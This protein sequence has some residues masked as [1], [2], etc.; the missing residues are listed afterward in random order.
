MLINDNG[1]AARL[2]YITRISRCDRHSTVGSV[3][4]LLVAVPTDFLTLGI[5]VGVAVT[6][7]GV[8]SSICAWFARGSR[9]ALLR[10]R[11]GVLGGPGV[12]GARGRAVGGTPTNFDCGAV[13][14]H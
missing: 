8:S 6:H 7:A 9:V 4:I 11:R 10:R 12:V 1:M 2:A 13:L 14:V 3:W 5:A